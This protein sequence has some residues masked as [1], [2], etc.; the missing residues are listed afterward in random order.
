MIEKLICVCVY[1]IRKVRISNVKSTKKMSISTKPLFHVQIIRA[2]Y[3]QSVPRWNY[4]HASTPTWRLYWN[5]SP[6]AWIK[7]KNTCI[8]LDKNKVIL[9]PPMFAFS[10][11]S[12][13]EFPHFFVH[14]TISGNCSN[15]NRQI[16]QFDADKIIPPQWQESIDTLDSQKLLW[17]G[18]LGVHLALMELPNDLLVHKNSIEDISLFEKACNIFENQ[19]TYGITCQ[20]LAEMCSTKVNT[21]QREF[22]KATGLSIQ[23][24]IL[25]RRMEKAAQLLLNEKQSIKETASFLGFADRYHF[26]KVFKNYFGTSPAQFIKQ[27]GIPLP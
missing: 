3:I 4:S 10:T 12:N 2:T 26:S 27:G 17:L 19:K 13:N 15:K 16:W 14:F 24:W 9:V 8:E 1:Y 18:T 6:G 25:N 11:G 22:F 7:H 5:P 21:L 20:T 23:K